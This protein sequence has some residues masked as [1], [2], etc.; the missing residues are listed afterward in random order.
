LHIDMSGNR[1]EP[2]ILEMASKNEYARFLMEAGNYVITV[3]GIDW[4]LYNGFIMPAY[5][6]HCC[7]LIT[8]EIAEKTL[9]IAGKPFA[10]W[11]TKFGQTEKGEWWY[12]LK[13]GPW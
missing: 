3:D 12:I 2:E 13:R 6:P 10:R 11:D 9:N 1:K 4:Y 8:N 7:P 5:L